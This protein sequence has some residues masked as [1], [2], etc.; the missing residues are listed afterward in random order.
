L[1]LKPPVSRAQK[2][3]DSEGPPATDTQGALNA[4]STTRMCRSRS[5]RRYLG[6]YT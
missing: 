3:H 1:K 4:S 5:Y 6:G 2:K